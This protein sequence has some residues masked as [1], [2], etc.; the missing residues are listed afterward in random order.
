M[1]LMWFI[2]GM[3]VVL[4]GLGMLALARR[5]AIDWKAWVG[6]ITGCLLVLFA[7]AWA[8]AS[9]AEGEPQ[10][11]AMGI[12]VFGGAGLVVL[13]LTWRLSI[14]PAVQGASSSG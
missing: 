14:Q 6:M 1:G 9:Y 7:I 2:E 13:A 11:G 3:L 12:V 10:S 5:Y 4:T 8:A